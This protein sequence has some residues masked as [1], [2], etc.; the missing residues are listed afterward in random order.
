MVRRLRKEASRFA[1]QDLSAWVWRFFRRFF[2]F[3][4]GRMEMGITGLENSKRNR[5]KGVFD[6]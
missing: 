6:S 4:A 3:A 2:D 5:L 1:M